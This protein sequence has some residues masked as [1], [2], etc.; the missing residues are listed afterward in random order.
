MSVLRIT[1]PRIVFFTLSLF[2]TFGRHDIPESRDGAEE[3]SEQVKSTGD[4]LRST[5]SSDT[6][7]KHL[8]KPPDK[9]LDSVE[10][11]ISLEGLEEQVQVH[12]LLV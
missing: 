1:F 4:E 9:C 8:H 3:F 7:D 2:R 6:N 10:I 11:V 5:C 12:R